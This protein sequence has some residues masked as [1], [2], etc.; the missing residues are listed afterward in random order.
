MALDLFGQVC[1]ESYGTRQISGTGGQADFMFGATRSK[2][3]KGFVC[4]SSTR[5]G[6]DGVNRSRVLPVLPPGS[7]VTDSRNLVSYVVTEYG[8]VNLRGKSTWERAEDIVSIA[9]PD[10]REGLIKEVERMKIWRKSNR[11]R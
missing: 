2:G 7:I 6:S 10:F 9:H 8:I 4:R 11:I 5:R 1:A 3:G